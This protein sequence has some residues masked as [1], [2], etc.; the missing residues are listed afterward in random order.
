MLT[1]WMATRCAARSGEG[2][3]A[4]YG[5]IAVLSSTSAESAQANSL[6]TFASVHGH[7]MGAAGAMEFVASVMA[8]RAGQLPP[9]AFL[10]TPDPRCDLDYIALEARSTGKLRAVMSN[11][12]AF[13]GSNS[14]LIARAI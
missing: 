11:S 13:G 7:A 4:I 5:V 8:L 2:I 3:I 9:T 10:E 1:K 6:S 14:V 12:F